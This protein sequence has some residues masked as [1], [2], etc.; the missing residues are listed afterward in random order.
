MAGRSEGL[1]LDAVDSTSPD[2]V[3]AALSHVWSWRGPQYEMYAMS[4]YLDYAPDFGKLTRWTGSLFGR[5]SGE[6]NAVIGGCQNILSYMLTGWETGL[7][8]QFNSLRRR[9]MSKQQILELVMFSALY[10]GDR[11]LAHVYHAVGDSLPAWAP[12]NRPVPFPDGWAPD[13]S[14]FASGLDLGSREL[15]ATDRRRLTDWY[16]RTIGY[17]PDSV[18]FGIKYESRFVKLNR[19]RWER[20]LRSLPK[21]LAPF[22]MLRHN[23]VTGSA[24]GLREATLLA[25]A[26]GL[27]VDQVVFAITNTAMYNTGFEGLYAADVIDDLLENWDTP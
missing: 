21:Q 13:P 22:L 4:L 5:L 19:A 27:T 7:R 18:R 9:G 16:E 15:T 12:P 23:T 11:G 26:W 14:A 8:S 2:E 6:A 24:A 20:T 25:R 3:A 10:T 17:L 1:D